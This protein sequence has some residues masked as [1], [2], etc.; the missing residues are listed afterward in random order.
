MAL[1]TSTWS[2][3]HAQ[4]DT[5]WIVPSGVGLGGDTLA[6]LRLCGS[7]A[8]QIQNETLGEWPGQC[9]VV[10]T[11]S[12]GHQ[13]HS[14]VPGFEPVNVDA[15]ADAVLELA[16]PVNSTHRMWSA[17]QRGDLLGLETMVRTG[18]QDAPHFEWNLNEWDPAATWDLAEGLEVDLTTHKVGEAVYDEHTGGTLATTW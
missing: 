16:L 15:G 1:V 6:A 2:I 11:D 7:P 14:S 12:V 5:L 10:N 8:F 3:S 4:T 17:S 18:W 9:V 13:L